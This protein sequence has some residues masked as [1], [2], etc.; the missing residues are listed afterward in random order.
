MKQNKQKLW[1]WK[2]L[3][4]CQCV[5]SVPQGNR[6][7]STHTHTHPNIQTQTRHRQREGFIFVHCPLTEELPVLFL[8]TALLVVWEMSFSSDCLGLTKN[9]HLVNCSSSLLSCRPRSWRLLM[10]LLLFSWCPH[11]SL[12]GLHTAYPPH[13]PWDSET[14]ITWTHYLFIVQKD[15]YSWPVTFTEC[16]QFTQHKTIFMEED[17]WTKRNLV[18]CYTMGR[19]SDFFLFR[20][21]HYF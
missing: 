2:T 9:K 7:I 14:Q 1:G 19:V 16:P 20:L 8:S 10:V 4:S 3:K 13:L 12:S 11:L 21:F 17:T 18:I 6:T 5:V 15:S